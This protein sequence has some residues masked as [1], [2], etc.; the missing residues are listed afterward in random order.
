MRLLEGNTDA[1]L[2]ASVHEIGLK[3]D[4]RK[5]PIEAVVVDN[6]LKTPT[7]N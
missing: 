2:F 7:E 5:A 1:S 3:L 6:V 4:P